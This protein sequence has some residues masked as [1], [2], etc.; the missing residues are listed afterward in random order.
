VGFPLVVGGYEILR[1][2]IE[3]VEHLSGRVADL[4]LRAHPR[5]ASCHEL[6]D[7][8]GVLVDQ[9]RVAGRVGSFWVNIHGLIPYLCILA[10]AAATRPHL[11]LG[12]EE[13]RRADA[14]DERSELARLD[15][16]ADA[17]LS[18]CESGP[19]DADPLGGL[20]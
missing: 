18:G 12:S 19:V 9:L 4:G 16:P 5:A 14:A 8:S 11:L 1:G 20:R 10:R 2:G 13:V 7:D 15:P 3:S 6:Q 17:T